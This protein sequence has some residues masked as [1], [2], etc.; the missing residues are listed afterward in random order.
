M[1]QKW[2]KHKQ[3]RGFQAKNGELVEALVN[4][5]NRLGYW[6]TAYA[7]LVKVQSR[8]A[9]KTFLVDGHAFPIEV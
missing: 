1:C 6:S 7:F 8:N 2:K 5:L 9:K 4:W 3:K